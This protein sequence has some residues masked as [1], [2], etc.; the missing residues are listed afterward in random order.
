MPNKRTRP[1]KS[2]I[3]EAVKDELE[4]G[5]SIN[6]TAKFYNISRAYLA[7]VIK[8]FKQSGNTDR[9]Y[10]HCPNIGKKRIFS[11]EQEDL[12]VSYLK[13]ASKMCH[14]LTRKKTR[15][16]AYEYAKSNN[17]CPDKWEVTK[18]ASVDWLRGF[19]T[20]HKDLAVRKPESTSLSRQLVST[21]QMLAYFLT[22]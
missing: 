9:A 16:L 17:I 4:N 6:K 18:T 20:R 3:E 12:L 21:K 7:K 5:Y 8:K 19:M 14:G 10:V 1:P 11:K 13:T 22:I 2:T 15:E